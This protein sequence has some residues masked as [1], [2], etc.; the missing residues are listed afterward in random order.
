MLPCYR[1]VK[2]VLDKLLALLLIAVLAPFLVLLAVLVYI[3]QRD[4]FFLQQRPGLLEKP[5]Y[6][7][8]FKTMSS[9][10]KDNH[11]RVS[12]FG[13]YLRKYSLDELP[14]LWNVLRGEMSLI[15]PRPYLMEYLT[16]YSDHHKGRHWVLPGMT[17]WAQ[18]NGGNELDWSR[19]LDLDMYYVRHMSFWLDMKIVVKT[20]GLLLSGA[21]KSQPNTRFLGYK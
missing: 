6:M 11:L 5:F 3:D 16:I 14:Q 13:R 20:L 8:K 4:V 7:L 17:G 19:K 15:G 21:R 18:V 12:E 10:A 9:G 2:F 1:S